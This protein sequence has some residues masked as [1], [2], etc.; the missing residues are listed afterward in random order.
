MSKSRRKLNYSIKDAAKEYRPIYLPKHEYHC[1][2]YLYQAVNRRINELV[3]E[4]LIMGEM[5]KLI[6]PER[7]GEIEI[8]KRRTPKGANRAVDYKKTKELGHVVYHNNRHSNKYFAKF[9]YDRYKAVFTNKS[10]YF[11]KPVRAVTR[12]LSKAIKEHNTIL[13]YNG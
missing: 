11:F 7:L 8:V 9:K 4:S 6:L 5:H 10:I 1:D 12:N 2:I 3:A 13:K